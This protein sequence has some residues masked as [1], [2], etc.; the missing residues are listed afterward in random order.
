VHESHD[1]E[2]CDVII[3][4]E[5]LPTATICGLAPSQALA[6]NAVGARFA[7]GGGLVLG[8]VMD[9]RFCASLGCCRSVDAQLGLKYVCKPSSCARG[10]CDTPFTN[11]C[12]RRGSQHSNR[13]HGG[14]LFLR[15]EALQNSI[16]ITASCSLFEPSGDI[17]QTANPN[18]SWTHAGICSPGANIVGMM[19]IPSAQ[20]SRT[21]GTDGF[22]KCSQLW[23]RC[24][25]SS[26]TFFIA[27]PS[28]EP[29]TCCRD[30]N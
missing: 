2:N 29:K 26:D 12:A 23:V 18:G 10:E 27:R 5:V 13:S 21:W 4:P 8:S 7:A 1:L 15:W 6:G 22:L 11:A 20:P 17:T 30:K 25:R 14:Q 16:V 28:A 19:R 24:L 9:S 3:V